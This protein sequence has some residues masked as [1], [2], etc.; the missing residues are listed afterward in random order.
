MKTLIIVFTYKYPY[1]PPTEQFL[2]T[3]IPYIQ[4]NE[5]D[6]YFVPTCRK[7][8]KNIRYPNQYCTVEIGRKGK[9]IEAAL[10]ISG[11]WKVRKDLFNDIK[12]SMQ[13]DKKRRGAQIKYIVGYYLQSLAYYC[14]LKNQMPKELLQCYSKVILYS[15][16][17]GSIAIAAGLYKQHLENTKKFDKVIAISRAHGQGD[18]Y[19]Q[20]CTEQLRPLVKLQNQVL[21]KVF[22]VSEAGKEY[23]KVQGVKGIQV[24][25]LGVSNDLIPKIE[26]LQKPIIP[27]IVSCSTINSNKRVDFIAKAISMLQ[28]RPVRWIH[29]GEGEELESLKRFCNENISGE[30]T[31]ELRGKIENKSL[32]EEYAKLE[33]IVFINASLVEGIPVSIMEAQSMAIPCIATDVGATHEIVENGVNGYLFAPDDPPE[34]LAAH[35][36]KVLDADIKQLNLWRYA[37]FSSWQ[38]NYSANNNYSDFAMSIL[39]SIC[40]E[41]AKET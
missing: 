38:C 17:L 15:Y 10:G 39:K 12:A 22:A 37:A 9:L 13:L 7:L 21:N 6:I 33:P 23:L 35:L 25:R 8:N 11:L 14:E 24:S 18:L 27:V 19:L 4:K 3:E 34:V 29:Y 16:W 2:D 30:I 32:L 5:C 31:W 36:R 26:Y 20:N 40:K 1:E 41:Q 28:E